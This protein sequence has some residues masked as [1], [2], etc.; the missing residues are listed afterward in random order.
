MDDTFYKEMGRRIAALRR[1]AGWSQEVLAGK[2]EV[3]SSYIARIEIGTRRPTLEVL[4]QVASALE[5]PLWRLITDSRLTSEERVWR[6]NA[7]ELS[8]LVDELPANDV[9]LLTQV[10]R[11]MHIA[12]QF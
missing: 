3:V 2:T 4:G 6:R 10:A 11:R 7:R 5:V 12:S 1:E 8:K 9:K